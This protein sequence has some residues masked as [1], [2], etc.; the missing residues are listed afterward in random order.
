[1][2]K[3]S[4]WLLIIVFFIS[5]GCRNKEKAAEKKTGEK[6]VPVRVTTLHS[7]DFWVTI[8]LV[9]TAKPNQ[10][11]FVKSKIPGKITRIY[12]DEGSRIRQGDLLA[13]LD[14][15]DYRLAVENARAA[16]KA[17]ELTF[18]EAEITLESIQKDWKRYK[19][20]YEKKVISKQKWDHMDAARRKARIMRDLA[21]ARVSRAN[22]ALEIALTNLKDTK[23]RAPFNGIITRRLVDPGD[24][25]YTMPPTVLMVVM[26]ISRVKIISD[27]PE[28]EMPLIR[29]STPVSLNF[30][31][32][33]AETFKGKITQI[34]PRVDPVTRNFT[35]EIALENPGQRIKAGMFAHV[36]IMARKIRGLLIPRSALL[37]I[38]GTGIFYTFRVTGDTVEKVNLITGIMEDRFVQVL[39]GLKDGDRVVTV[40]NARLKTGRKI[41]IIKKENPA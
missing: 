40:G 19:K 18:R 25:V 15:V 13:E 26:D 3:L 16:L 37:K 4:L 23:I 22:V 32:F 5:T 35:I 11:V 21:E 27:V 30:D 36:K 10:V 9:G 8:S 20:L 2:K 41:K 14:P 34:Y 24:R 28:K 7:R 31:A 33:P 12:V 6:P 39:K 29:H 38:P 1:M 17:A